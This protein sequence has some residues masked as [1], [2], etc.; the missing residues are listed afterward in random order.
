METTNTIKK[1]IHSVNTQWDSRM[2]FTSLVNDHLIH[3]DKLPQHGGDNFG[4][5]PKPLILAAIG[6]C[7][8][9]EV[10]AILDKMRI[11]IAGLEIQVDG[12]LSEE[13]PKMYKII[14]MKLLVKSAASDKEKIERAI[15]LAMDKYC[16]VVAMAR[17]FATIN[18]Q[19]IFHE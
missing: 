16:G 1:D 12:E 9:M 2:H 3:M 10:I 19:I 17:K 5:R 18:S 8:S 4:P 6:G 11:K 14:D 15:H 13:Q 7:V